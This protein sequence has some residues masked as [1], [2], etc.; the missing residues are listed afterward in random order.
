MGVI[1]KI[2]S[3]N[4]D[5]LRGFMNIL[6]II[7]LICII[8]AIIQ[9][10]RKGFLSQAISIAS[11]FLGTW[12]ACE[13]AITTGCWMSRFITAPEQTLNIIAFI[14]ILIIACIALQLFCKILEKLLEFITLG[15]V[16]KL[17]GMVFALIKCVLILG[18]AALVFDYINDTFN[19]VSQ[20]YIASSSLYGTIK[21]I[22]DVVFP[23]IKNLLTN[24]SNE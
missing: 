20:E 19:L 11:L 5:I 23:F 3:A 24:G 4:I 8:P 22:A 14:V 10:I 21:E 16:N 6:D 12:L 13:F 2:Q 9:G 17:L 7:I 1:P 18:V 15:W